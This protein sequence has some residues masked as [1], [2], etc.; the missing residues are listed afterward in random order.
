MTILI[1]EQDVEQILSIEAAIPVAE[2]AF[3]MAGEGSAHNPPRFRMPFDGGFLQF[4]PAALRDKKVMGCKLWANFDSRLRSTPRQVW[5]FL[6]STETRDLLA[7]VQAY[8][9]GRFRTSA[10]TAVAV[11]HLS[12]GD[13][14]SVGMYG[15]GRQAETQLAAVCAV[16]PIQTARIYCRTPNNRESFCRKMSERLGIDVI[17]VGAPEQA[18]RDADIVITITNTETPVLFG[19]WL[20]RPGLVV[21]AGANHWYEREIDEKVVSM[22]KLIVVDEKEQAKVE[23]GDLLWPIARG[24]LTW[25]QVEEMGDIVTGRVRVPDFRRNTILFESYGTG[26]HDLAISAKAYELAKARGVGRE[27]S[28]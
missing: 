28:L 27:I 14:S 10:V 7:V 2:E 1:T 16:R 5:N 9:I 18:A 23:G 8:T 24:L 15:A 12:P 26:I 22:A 6:F 25:D 17:P 13:A 4:G 21:G 20:V 11:K 19:D 3:R